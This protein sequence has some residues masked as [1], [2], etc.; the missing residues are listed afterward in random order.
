[1]SEAFDVA[2]CGAGP[3]GMALACLLVARGMAPSRIALV[4]A[5]PLVQAQQD[6]RSIALSY[7]SRQLLEQIGAWPVPATAIHEIHVSRRGRLGRSMIERGEQGVPAL[8]YVTRYGEL[9]GVMAAA[10]ERA[11]VQVLRPARVT[12]NAEHS[13]GVVLRLDDGREIDAGVVV[14]A[15]GGV[16]G[17][18]DA[19]AVQRDYGQT[20]VIARVSAS[21]PI[22]HRAFERFTDEGPLALLPQD[23]SDGHQYALVWCASPARAGALL[24]LEEVQFLAQLGEAFG[25]R[26]GKFVAAS[27]RVSYPL[28]L[29]AEPRATARTVAIG[30]AAQTLHPVA[31]QGLNLGLR[32]AAVLAR[33]LAR[34]ASLAEFTEAR[35]ADRKTTVGLT[36]AMARVFANEGPAQALLGLSLGV[37]DAVNP[38]RTVLAELMMFGRR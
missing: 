18:Q 29:N 1:M 5:K 25:G 32:D 26:L 2:I 27:A 36:D 8:G 24:A 16:F 31:G 7:G 11:G 33:L 37:I 17:E 12:G 4:D 34:G 20:A 15:E 38:A 35:A 13:E 3:V 28:G 10:C 14:Q 23:A 30:N 9:V 19:R 6:P 22:A 21:T